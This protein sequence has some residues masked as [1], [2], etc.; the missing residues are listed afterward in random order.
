MTPYEKDFK[1]GIEPKKKAHTRISSS[2]A[3]KGWPN[4]LEKAKKERARAPE[5]VMEK[6]LRLKRSTDFK[7]VFKEGKRFPS[8]RFV[9]YIRK[10]ALPQARLGVSIS[11]SHFKL[12]TRRNRLR[13]IARELFRKDISRDFKGYDFVIASR[14]NYPSSDMSEAIKELKALLGKMRK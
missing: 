2:D 9:L 10:N 8:P 11:K 13:R 14:R 12:A 6:R 5:R 4:G 1:A 7:K 3:H